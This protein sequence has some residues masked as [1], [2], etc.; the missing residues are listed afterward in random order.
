M[1]VL[2]NLSMWPIGQ[3]GNAYKM[4]WRN[5]F[6]YK[7][8]LP[9]LVRQIHDFLE[10]DFPLTKLTTLCMI[11]SILD[12]EKSAINEHLGCMCQYT[13][14]KKFYPWH[15]TIS[16]SI[17]YEIIVFGSQTFVS[18]AQTRCAIFTELPCM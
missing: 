14:S 3:V 4:F 16:S 17:C 10:K 8:H 15:L 5:C 2:L 1:T 11:S 9:K 7:T 13:V 6:Q 18:S 12:I